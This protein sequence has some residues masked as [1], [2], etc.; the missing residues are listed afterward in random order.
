MTA[1]EFFKTHDWCQHHYAKTSDGG[2]CH[3]DD[4]AAVSFCLTGALNVCYKGEGDL[5]SARLRVL[6]VIESL[7]IYKSICRF[8]DSED[9]TEQEVMA[10]LCAAGA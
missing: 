7:Y 3:Y 2:A 10:V 9:R 1:Y 4:P 5:E 8:N 6:G